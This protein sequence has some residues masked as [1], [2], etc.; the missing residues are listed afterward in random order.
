[1][2]NSDKIEM[3]GIVVENLKGA[4]FNV[5]LIDN[6]LELICTLGGKLRMNNIRVLPNDKVTVQI[7]PYDLSKGI[8]VWRTK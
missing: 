3:E 6:N 4:K 1:M 7:S 5:K 8:I 2:S